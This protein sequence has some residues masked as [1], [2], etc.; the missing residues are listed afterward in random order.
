MVIQSNFSI[1]PLTN[2]GTHA[3]INSIIRN[4]IWRL[5]FMKN[6]TKLLLIA[7]LVCAMLLC[8]CS[9]LPFNLPENAVVATPKTFTKDGMSITLTDGFSES[10][11]EG[12]VAVY[13]RS[14]AKLDQTGYI[15]TVTVKKDSFDSL[16]D[17]NITAD[18]TLI[19]YAQAVMEAN[20]LGGLEVKTAYD[21]EITYF[22]FNNLPDTALHVATVFKS[23]DAFWLIQFSGHNYYFYRSN[24]N[25]SYE[26][27]DY[28]T[29]QLLS[30]ALESAKTVTIE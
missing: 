29:Y 24:P 17:L 8:G 4:K 20:Q 13:N 21:G 2:F 14:N 23:A 16:S 7:I 18:S 25:V 9:E 3:I 6:F 30:D 15:E 19:D 12:F 27:Y 28:Y 1:S 11:Q 26:D 10:T 5:P 22:T